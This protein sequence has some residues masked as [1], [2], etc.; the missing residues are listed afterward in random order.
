MDLS[1]YFDVFLAQAKVAWEADVDLRRNSLVSQSH[2]KR[3]EK[4]PYITLPPTWRDHLVKLELCLTRD[5]LWKIVNFDTYCR[6]W[7]YERK[8]NINEEQLTHF[9]LEKAGMKY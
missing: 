8:S 9:F 5:K 3:A 7:Y 2:V 1:K 4:D 6:Q